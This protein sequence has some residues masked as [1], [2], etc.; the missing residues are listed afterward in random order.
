MRTFV[1]RTTLLV[2][3]AVVGVV[4][5]VASGCGGGG[6]G[7]SAPGQGA[8]TAAPTAAD[9]GVGAIDPEAG[10]APTAEAAPEATSATAPT[11]A[12]AP[13]GPPHTAELPWG[14][15]TLDN[16]IAG[17]LAVGERLNLVLSAAST[18]AGGSGEV[19]GGGWTGAAAGFDADLNMRIV[20]P[21]SA[22]QDEQVEIIHSLLDSGSIDCLAVEADGADSFVEV[23]DRAVDEGV[24]TFTVGGDSAESRRFAF[25]GLDD[26]AAGH[27]VGTAAGEWAAENRI[28]MAKAGVLTG[29]ADNP[30]YQARI[31]GFIEGLLSIHSGVEFANGPTEGVESLGFDPEAVRT[32]ADAWVGAHL[33]VDMV[34]HT[35]RGM[36]QVA[37]VIAER[38]LY[39]DM[40]TSGFHMSADLANYIRDGVVVVAV[41]QGLAAQASSAAAACA[42]FLLE[43]A[44]EVG[45]VVHEPLLATRDNVEAVDWT[46]PEN[47]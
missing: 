8:A 12:P 6:D 25:Y 43:G 32:A 15:F 45:R 3:I 13:S 10:P 31:E 44:Y 7:D 29:D 21:N 34:F 37:R 16:R 28:L 17:K 46:L 26:R 2:A 38:S 27:L 35:D 1:Q 9:G 18:G 36:A 30:R 42:Q 22:D 4:A 39:G 33:D 14:D 23:I 5:L 24:P 41:A 20:G 47:Q 40:Y 11:A 19:M